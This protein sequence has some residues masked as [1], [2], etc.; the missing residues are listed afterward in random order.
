MSLMKMYSSAVCIAG[1]RRLLP[2]SISLPCHIPFSVDY[3][4]SLDL[5]L[6]FGVLVPKSSRI[7]RLIKGGWARRWP[8]GSL[9]SV[10]N[11]TAWSATKERLPDDE[12]R[13]ARAHYK[14]YLRI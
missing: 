6:L 1:S 4:F 2:R 11:A 3:Y 14:H 8:A 12:P 5:L 7:C 9:E 10:L 13:A